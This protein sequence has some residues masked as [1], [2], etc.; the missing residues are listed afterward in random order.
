MK[1]RYLKMIIDIIM[2]QLLIVLMGYFMTTN[3]SHEILG[4]LTITLFIVHLYFNKQWFLNMFKGKYSLQRY[5]YVF[6]NVSLITAFIFVVISS[7]MIS[8]YVFS[9]LPFSTSSLARHM[10][11]AST[12]WLFILI[13]LH[14]GFH[15]RG[16]VVKISQKVTNRAY[17]YI[18]YVIFISWY[19]YGVIAFQ[20]A[21]LYKDMFV[22][23]E[24]KFFDYSMSP[25]VFY[26]NYLSIVYFISMS[27]YML[28]RFMNNRKKNMLYKHKRDRNKVLDI[29]T[30]N[31][32][33]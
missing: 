22:L 32:K 31:N 12:S 27:C 25:F 20:N 2:L 24:F 23:S 7:V 30:K 33:I 3:K 11:L 28:M 6:V 16:L 1:K 5:V 14:I 4:T 13:S 8:S 21:E 18:C 17:Q 26:V 15:L 9:W 29:S 19:I 10:H